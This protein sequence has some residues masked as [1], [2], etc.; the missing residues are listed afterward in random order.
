MTVF[1]RVVAT[2]SFSAAARELGMSQATASK[3]IQTLEKW[4]G[5]RLLHRTTRRVDL[6]EAGQSFHGQC[7][8]ILEDME[9]AREAG[10]PDARL[11]GTLRISAPVAFGSTRF[12]G[13]LVD[14]MRQYNELSVAV[15][16]CDRPVDVIEEGYDL[17][18]RVGHEDDAPLRQAGLVSRPLTPM[19]FVVCAAPSYLQQATRPSAP[20]DLARHVCLT[21]TRH[22]GDIWR[23]R[24]PEGEVEVSVSGHLKTDNGLLRRSAALA[25]AGIL[26]APS[27][28]VEADLAAGRL[29]A[30]LP[31]YTTP[32]ASLDVVCPAHRA[33]SPKVRAFIGFLGVRLGAGEANATTG[34]QR[35]MSDAWA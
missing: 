9:A 35:R 21:D 31:E 1:S 15:I 19:G 11:R 18:I 22:P 30:L 3:H 32:A 23:F 13:L 24:G 6:T 27:F 8:R 14:F 20:A 29:V 16:L 4:L 33:A 7:T 10:K 34:G 28:L 5:A 25:G 26:L 17:A 2:G 12:G